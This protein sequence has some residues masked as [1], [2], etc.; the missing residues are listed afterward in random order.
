MHS[1]LPGSIAVKFSKYFINNRMKYLS[2]CLLGLFLMPGLKVLGAT[3]ITLLSQSDP[4]SIN[5][6][7]VD[8]NGVAASG[9]TVTLSGETQAVTTTAIDGRYSFSNLPAGGN[10]TVTPT[11]DLHT[12][13]PQNQSFSNLS[14]S[15]TADFVSSM[16][17]F[18]VSGMV[19][20]SRGVGLGGVTVGISGTRNYATTS[21]SDGSYTFSELPAGA[22][23]TVT[24]TSPEYFFFPAFRTFSNVTGNR[25]A[26]F[27]ATPAVYSISGV[28]RA[29]GSGSGV[30]GVPVTL[31]GTRTAATVSGSD[32]SYAFTS[33][34]PGGNYTVSV[35]YGTSGLTHLLLAAPTSHSF[36]RLPTNLR[37][38][39]T[40]TPL[41]KPLERH[42]VGLEA[43]E[44][45]GDGK[46]D[47]VVVSLYGAVYVLLGKGDGTFERGATYQLNNSST[48]VGV[49]DFD[50]NGVSDV[51]VGNRGVNNGPSS[52]F[53]L[54]GNGD[55]TFAVKPAMPAVAEVQSIAISDFDGDGRVDIVTA[56]YGFLATGSSVS[57]VTV[58]LGNGDGTFR[59]T[60]D[61]EGGFN[62]RFVIAADFSGDGKP[63]LATTNSS[64]FDNI[65]VFLN[66]GDGTFSSSASYTGDTSSGALAAGDFNADGKL[67]L[68]VGTGILNAN[69]VRI[70]PGNGDGTFQ[71]PTLINAGA[72]PNRI[73]IADL[74]GDD[75][76]DL[77]VLNMDKEV[78]VLHGRGDNTFMNA[79]NYDHSSDPYSYAY[80]FGLA[81]FNNDGRL[82]VSI[83][84]YSGRPGG[85]YGT[86]H[87]WTMLN[88]PTLP[89]PGGVNSIA[90]QLRDADG[91]PIAGA[92]VVF[93]GVQAG[94]TVTD[95][96]GNYSLTNIN[97]G[98]EVSVMPVKP[99][100]S[101]SPQ[102]RV[103]ISDGNTSGI[104][105][106]G[107][108][109]SFKVS[110]QIK[111]RGN[112]LANTVVTLNSAASVAVRMTAVTD[113]EGNY[114]FAS[115]PAGEIY[116]IAP[117]RSSYGFSPS[118]Q[119]VYLVSNRQDINFN[120]FAQPVSVQ[121]S[122]AGYI[123][124]EG[125][126]RAVIKITRT[127]NTAGIASVSY[128]TVDNPAAVRCDDTETLPGTAFARCDY[129]TSLD[130]VSF[131][132]GEV[133]KSFTV[134]VI[135]DAH[136]EGGETL[137]LTLLNATGAALGSQSTASLSINDNDTASVSNPIYDSAFF[138]RMQYLDFLSREPE[139]GEPWTGVLNRCPDVNNNPTCDRIL[140]S[141]SFF[142]SPEFRLKGF[143]ALTFYKVAFNRLPEYPEIIADMR[144][145][146][147]QTSSD[148]FAKR[149]AFPS[150][151]VDRQEFKT[152]YNSLSN[153]EFVNALLDR[154][155]SQTITTPDPANPEGGTH[156]TL[157][158][159]DLISRL[160]ATG[161]AALTRAQVLRAV[162]ESN[163]VAAAEYNGA[164]VA[165]QYYG[166]L[167]RKPEEEG[168]NAWL[169]VITEEPQNVR[170]MVNGFMN[171]TEYRLRFGQP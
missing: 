82:D 110:G 46:P 13:L 29:S 76:L 17:T 55:G 8:E 168:Y 102:A 73:K 30:S 154:Y 167:R 48:V 54:L 61:Y 39:F 66:R 146:A 108:R 23:Y 123:V 2:V 10:Y 152:A 161:A 100:Y 141:Q 96:N 104:D 36:D 155:R 43:G 89:A 25:V 157:T 87:V 103:V 15:V 78:H 169:R 62:M 51:V 106:I 159:G 70:F 144:N 124:G 139:A 40:I 41:I 93:S 57:K 101:F 9:V 160:G 153:T 71:S 115:V 114:S 56:N 92:S 164:F 24:P 37:A 122:A 121:F 52:L 72:P 6:L 107:N 5:G 75:K 148:T 32:G 60:V 90:G 131:A 68:A 166:Y 53:V 117:A 143:Y 86:G 109:E 171:S 128:A 95:E 135:D 125:D 156:V 97:R 35:S 137:R 65:K 81:D 63:D 151:F 67:D 16:S 26:S 31:S 133:E 116:V 44:F 22:S 111:E 138:V 149:A 132:A 11:K 1:Q 59:S 42:L 79:V 99:F 49:A 3:G 18:K 80:G 69:T 165:M 147:G 158:R 145:V 34:P 150:A 112:G 113:G 19:T 94:S 84:G 27:I 120:A 105:F 28:V 12:F 85:E 58:L 129:A 136:I 98:A 7:I 142:G 118:Q 21:A 20:D 50:G 119:S 77:V 74:N 4:L 126:G 127:G 140:V 38:D 88:S 83:S 47:V 162:V 134:P 45:N 163:E 91:N 130:T 33:L 64:S 170:L 14:T